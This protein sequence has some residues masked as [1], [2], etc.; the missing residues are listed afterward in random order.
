MYVYINVLHVYVQAPRK[1][2]TRQDQGGVLCMCVS[3]INHTYTYTYV[4]A[5]T[6]I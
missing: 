3:D 2:K 5:H 1:F 6:H 4:H